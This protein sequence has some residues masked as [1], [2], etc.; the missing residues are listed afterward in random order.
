MPKASWWTETVKT[1]PWFK[2]SGPESKSVIQGCAVRVG[3]AQSCQNSPQRPA[4][5]TLLPTPDLWTNELGLKAV[6]GP[7][8]AFQ[9]NGRPKEAR[10]Q[11]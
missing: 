1:L 9:T 11:P 7:G 8:K 2:G 6:E 5:L 4:E 3:T 10:I